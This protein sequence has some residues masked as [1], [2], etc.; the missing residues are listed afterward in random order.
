M[1]KRLLFFITFLLV[2]PFKVFASDGSLVRIGNNYYDNLIDAIK[3]VKNNETI[4]LVNDNDV[5][6]SI[7]INKAVKIDLNGYDIMT[8]EAVFKVQGGTLHLTGKG[9]IIEKNPN[10]GAIMMYGS[11]NEDDTNYSV[12]K[13]DKD[14]HLEGWSGIFITHDAL[15]AYGILVNFEGTINAVND[16]N[17][18]TGIGIYV[19]GN[20]K[21]SLNYPI[22]NIG[23]S[24][25]I[26]STGS[27]IYMAGYMELNLDGGYIQGDESAIGMKSGILNINSGTIISTGEDKTP[28]VGNN[29]GIAPSGT[30]IQI[31]SN[32]NYA[33]N[34]KIK[35]NNGLIKSKN[36]YAVYEY[37]GKGDNSLVK[38]INISNGQ[39]ES[40]KNNFYLSDDF[41]SKH[42]YFI[43][44]GLFTNDP[45]DFLYPGYSSIINK[46]NLYEVNMSSFNQVSKTDKLT[47]SWLGYLV[48]VCLLIWLSIWGYKK[49]K[50]LN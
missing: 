20:I 11:N 19:N 15:K 35:I 40:N 25:K 43:E 1:N 37:I 18:N 49:I 38:T 33:G 30:A 28:S 22:V 39:F 34:M 16:E 3:N 12:V 32:S 46:N 24:A 8:K 7:T 42:P 41:K 10:Y 2:I 31:E 21:H 50:D 47:K 36:S 17:N 14:V 6:D 26:T 45:E 29:N 23:K 44:G 4:V 9:Q 48:A 5:L 13:V 27:G